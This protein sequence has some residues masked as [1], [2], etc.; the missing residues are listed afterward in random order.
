[1]GAQGYGH[2]GRVVGGA[3]PLPDEVP[4]LVARPGTATGLGRPGESGAEEVEEWPENDAGVVS[5]AKL[6]SLMREVDGRAEL[7]EEAEDVMLEIVDDFITSVTEMGCMLAKHR[8]SATLEAKDLQYHLRRHWGI[9]VP[10]VGDGA[11]RTHRP[12]AI[13]SA[14]HNRRMAAVRAARFAT[15][16]PAPKEEA[17][18]EGKAEDSGQA[19]EG[20]DPKDK[21]TG[22]KRVASKR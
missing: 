10:G 15:A 9:D 1:M 17:V 14:A 20:K 7:T 18:E 5:R 19:E 4:L 13:A 22:K 16:V 6:Q 11:V 12:P 3:P 8:K 21:V 2:H